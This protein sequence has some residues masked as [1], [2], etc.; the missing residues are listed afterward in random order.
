M[1]TKRRLWSDLILDLLY[2][3][4]CMGC[5]MAIPCYLDFFCLPCLYMLAPLDFHYYKNNAVNDHFIGRCDVQTATALLPYYKK[6]ISQNMVHNVKY[7]SQFELGRFI[8]IWLGNLLRQSK[9]YL[10]VDAIVPVPLHRKKQRRRGYNQSQI[11]SDGLA[12]VL[13]CPVIN[14]AVIRDKRTTSQTTFYRMQRSQNMSEVFTAKFDF[15]YL[16]KIIL[17]DDVITTGATI[18]GCVNAIRAVNKNVEINVVA[19]A[20]GGI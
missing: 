2:P 5:G 4:C 9:Y 13:H 15:K 19:M 6:S 17:V 14:D 12:E 11:I 18:E 3:P 20:I 16:D 8:G 10:H 7:R 1:Y